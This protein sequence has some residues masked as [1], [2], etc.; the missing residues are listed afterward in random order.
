MFYF[1]YIQNLFQS[2]YQL[3]ATINNISSLPWLCFKIND[4]FYW[5][6]QRTWQL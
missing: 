5:L 3:S 1:L 4:A 2:I 6:G